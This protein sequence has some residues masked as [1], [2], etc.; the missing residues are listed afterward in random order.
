MTFSRAGHCPSLFYCKNENTVNYLECDGMG[1]GILRNS[2][3]G[4]YVH[5]NTLI[6]RAG[7]TLLL[8]TDGITEAK[9]QNGEQFGNDRLKASF[10]KHA[11][12][13]PDQIKEGISSDLS[14][15]M[16]G[17][18]IDDDYTLVVVQFKEQKNG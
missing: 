4:N 2:S 7:D 3:Y 16:G 11:S 13:S 15:F 1:L 9:S 14:E 5:S 6:Y 12:K 10:T 18:I 8:Y 17:M